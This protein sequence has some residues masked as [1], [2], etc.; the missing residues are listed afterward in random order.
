MVNIDWLLTK[1]NSK[2]LFNRYDG[3]DGSLRN[4][5]GTDEIGNQ[6]SGIF[7]RE[8]AIKYLIEHD[9]DPMFEVMGV[10][11]EMISYCKYKRKKIN[12][13]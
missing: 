12:Q 6:M 1:S 7:L 10:D 13:C 8:Y 4:P 9:I 11:E 3:D 5:R 2:R